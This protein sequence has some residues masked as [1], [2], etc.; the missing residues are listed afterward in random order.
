MNNR[1]RQAREALILN[2]LSGF[3]SIADRITTEALGAYVSATAD[4]S[5]D[6]LKAACGDF[7]RAEVPGWN[8]NFVLTA[9]QLAERARMWHGLLNRVAGKD[10]LTSYPIGAPLPPGKEPLGPLKVDFGNG[11]IDMSSM[12]YAE[13]EAVLA[14]KG[15]PKPDDAAGGTS[16]TVKPRRM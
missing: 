15:L 3:L 7:Q 12:S 4:Y 5:V 1:E 2:L 13:K 10:K 8:P 14:A 9:P 6:A 16:I 11:M